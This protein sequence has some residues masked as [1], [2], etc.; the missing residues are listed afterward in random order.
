MQLGSSVSLLWCLTISLDT[1]LA[2]LVLRRRVFGD[3][4]L[5][6]LYALISPLRA[7]VLFAVY[8]WTG[9][10]SHPAFYVAWF[11]QALLLI[12]RGTVCAE[13][14]RQVLQRYSGLWSLARRVLA[15]SVVAIA[16]YVAVDALRVSV[17]SVTLIGG[18]GRGM[19]AAERGTE[20]TIS[21]VMLSLLLAALRYGIAIRRTPLLLVIGLC[22]YSLVQTINNVLLPCLDSI[23][24]QRD[25]G[26]FSWWND[27]R[28]VSFQITLVLWILAFVSKTPAPREKAIEMVPEV[29][30]KHAEKVSQELRTLEKELEEVARR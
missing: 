7:L 11:T 10:L 20:L 30:A 5:V 28:I 17:P 8:H 18:F 22:F 21:F 4:P 24:H 2:I 1:V 3:F 9:Y 29:Y 25:A 13:L 14:C 26:Q 12:C 6:V 16:V 19:L 23:L 27:F 15:T